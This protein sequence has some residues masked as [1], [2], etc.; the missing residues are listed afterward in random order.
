MSNV[1]F[2]VAHSGRGRPTLHYML[3]DGEFMGARDRFGCLVIEV[4]GRSRR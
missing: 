1:F 4:S 3:Y 2:H